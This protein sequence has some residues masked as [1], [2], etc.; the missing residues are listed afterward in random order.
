MRL[1]SFSVSRPLPRT[2]QG[3][4]SFHS[5]IT[6]DDDSFDGC[7]GY[8]FTRRLL[9]TSSTHI[10][11]HHEC[12]I[13]ENPVNGDLAGAH[14]QCMT[15]PS[16]PVLKLCPLSFSTFQWYMYRSCYIRLPPSIPVQG[17]S[18]RS[19]SRASISVIGDGEGSGD[20]F[21]MR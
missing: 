1:R 18:G 3:P 16:H 7:N 11:Y 10:E 20:L 15:T 19:K 8:T 12:R 9:R 17:Y 13:P 6:N 21:R 14:W 4:S 5:F 2:F